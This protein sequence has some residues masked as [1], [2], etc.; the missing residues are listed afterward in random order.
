[1]SVYL[2]FFFFSSRRRH[3]RFDCDWSSDVCSSD[4][5]K[6]EWKYHHRWSCTSSERPNGKRVWS[7]L[8]IL[9]DAPARSSSARSL[10]FLLRSHLVYHPHTSTQ[11]RPRQQCRILRTVRHPKMSQS[12]S[13]SLTTSQIE[14]HARR[15][16]RAAN[17]TRILQQKLSHSLD[18]LG[19][20]ADDG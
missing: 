2:F 3:T 11:R 10:V 13:S 17:C 8:V 12:A 18:N 4:L 6:R 19:V 14:V 15:D 16:C 1:M 9:P 5:A 7:S 20:L